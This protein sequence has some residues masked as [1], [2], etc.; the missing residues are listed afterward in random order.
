MDPTKEFQPFVKPEKKVREFTF[1]AIFL[2]IILGIIFNLGNTYLGL[3]VGMTISASIPAAVLSMAIL[4]IFFKDV[5]ILENNLVQTIASVGEG[6]AAGIIFTVPALFIL[7]AQISNTK[8]FILSFCGGVLGILFMIPMRR[9][10]IVK[11][12]KVLPFPEGT[13]CAEILKAGTKEIKFAIKAIFGIMIGAFY[14][15]CMSAFNLFTEVATFV[16]KP[17]ESTEFRI[18]VTPSLLGVGYIVGLEVASVMLAGGALGWWVFIPMIKLYSSPDFVVYPS[19]IP[20][21]QMDAVDIWSSYVRYIGIGTVAVGGVV[22]LLGIFPVIGKSIHVGFKELFSSASKESG[23]LRTDQDISMKWLILGSIFITIFLWLCPGLNM[24][25]FTVALLVLLGYF[26]VAVTSITVGLVGSSSNPAS[27]MVLTTLLITGI[28]FAFL[29]WTERAYLIM[30]ITMGVVVTVAICL[31]ATTSQDLKTGFLLGATPRKQQVAEIIGLI[32]PSLL[33]GGVLVLLNKAYVFGS[34]NLPAPQAALLTVVGEG[35]I[36]GKLPTTLVM[37]GVVIGFALML[38]KVR[39]LPFAIGLY[40]PLEVTSP[41]IIG[42]IVNYFVKKSKGKD[43]VESGV[44]VSSGLVA[45]DA[46]SGVLI[47]LLTVMGFIN[48][49]APSILGGSY[50]L[51]F[52]ILL[53]L[54]LYWMSIGKRNKNIANK[55]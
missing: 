45:G 13:A 11:E 47:A 42:G 51:V 27:G 18:D 21:S 16:I 40:L 12:H 55:T 1:R 25:L 48:P 4:R 22:N 19:T 8:I 17:F 41:M 52:F 23:L 46:C 32:F 7:G 14:K 3:K 44:L 9:Y 35:V 20:I 10:I 26:F 36:L 34:Q 33:I 28:L 6:L 54:L 31:A 30:A 24:N 38:L 2:G 39:I 53:G 37:L 15:I 29:G 49:N 50:S 43:N 5:T